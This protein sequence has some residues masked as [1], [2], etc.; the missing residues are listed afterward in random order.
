M[1]AKFKDKTII[2]G[3]IF[4][5]QPMSKTIKIVDLENQAFAHL[6]SEALERNRI[7]H[8]IRSHHDSVYDGVFQQQLGWGHVEAPEEYKMQILEIYDD[9][10]KAYDKE[11]TSF[12]F[13]GLFNTN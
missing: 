13:E 7:P 6:L 10:K 2:F 8:L 4:L 5:F 9:L 1:K 11:L 12:N 3:T